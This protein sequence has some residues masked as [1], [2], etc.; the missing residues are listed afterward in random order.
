MNY[1]NLLHIGAFNVLQI[2][3]IK[4]IVGIFLFYFITDYI[5]LFTK[6]NP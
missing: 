2:H 5:H 1:F 6:K 4:L 3:E